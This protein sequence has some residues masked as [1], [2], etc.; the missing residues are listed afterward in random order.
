MDVQMSVKQTFMLIREGINILEIVAI[1]TNKGFYIANAYCVQ[2]DY[3]WS[4]SGLD[5]YYF[6]G[7]KAKPT[8]DKMWW[9]VESYPSAVQEMRNQPAINMRFELK[10][11]ELCSDKIPMLLSRDECVYT[12]DDGYAQWY[13]PYKTYQSL[14]EYKED[15]QPNKLFDVEFTIETIVELEIDEIQSP[16]EMNY[17]VQ[18]TQWAHEGTTLLKN[19]VV[20]HQ[21]IDKIICPSILLHNKPCSLS[22]KQI[23]DILRQYIKENI[24]PK[25]A[26]ITS[27][28][29]FCFTVKKLIGLSNPV[30]RR[31]EILN[32]RGRS[33]KN[34]KYKYDYAKA[35]EVEIFEMTHK[36]DNY[37]GYTPINGITADNE[38]DLQ[39]KVDRLCEET[40]ALIN[41]PL[42][43]C[44]HC[45]GYG[46][47]LSE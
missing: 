34:P 35:R 33:Y 5:R 16:P 15:K 23:Y 19:D 4:N 14:Y 3:N 46:V 11:N 32:S 30:E 10:D 37:K 22:S 9:F 39:A 26:H 31:R 45:Q 13:E 21:V 36:E 17:S 20:K 25:V 7:E 6:N 42:I 2:S 8:F 27:D 1:K 12:D 44:P 38:Y 43:E 24:N 47:V 41:E 40:L 29:N 28:Y 18:R